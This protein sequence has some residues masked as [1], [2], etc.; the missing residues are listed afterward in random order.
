MS[1][2]SHLALHFFS[3]SLNGLLLLL[4][5]FTICEL[6][7]KFYISRPDFCPNLTPMLP[8]PS[9]EFHVEV[10]LAS[11]NSACPSDDPSVRPALPSCIIVSVNH[12]PV[13]R[14]NSLPLPY[15]CILT[16]STAYNFLLL[17]T[18]H[19]FLPLSISTPCAQCRSPS[20]HLPHQLCASH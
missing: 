12:A 7:S 8:L 3:L 2:I 15:S 17:Q 4:A 18:S 10:P 1:L 20:E 16:T 14:P 19:I 6:H 13:P 11:Q 5:S 9:R